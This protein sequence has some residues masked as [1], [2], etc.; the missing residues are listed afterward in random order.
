MINSRNKGKRGELMLAAIFR[1][2]GYPARRGQQYSGANGDADVVGVPFVHI[3]CKW[4]NKTELHKWISQSVHDA[5]PGE[6]PIV[7]HKRDNEDF[8]V[9]L[10]IRDFIE[11]FNEYAS[12][13][14]LA[15]MEE[16]HEANKGDT[17]RQDSD[18]SGEEGKERHHAG[19]GV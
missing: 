19:R 4:S 2:Y 17:M 16:A 3:E 8:F 7:C 6:I 1:E 15:E 13:R 9:T 14:E 10:H 11:I 18:S 5:K 12:G